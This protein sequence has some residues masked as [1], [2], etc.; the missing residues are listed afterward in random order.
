MRPIDRG[1]APRSY[2]QYGDA[3]EDLTAQLGQYCSYCERHIPVGLAVEHVLPKSL[4]PALEKTWTNFLLSC[5]NCN[6]VKGSQAVKIN[7][8][9]WPDRDNTF[10]AIIYSKGGFVTLANNLNTKQ[11]ANAQALLDLVGLQRH[12][13][14]GWDRPARRDK[15]WQDRENVWTAAERCKELF[16]KLGKSVEARELV[17]KFAQSRGFFSIWMIVFENYPDVKRELIQLL[18]GTATPCFDLNGKPLSRP[19]ATI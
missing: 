17:L 8:L 4:H 7:K 6:S 9:L 18:P 5:T 11:Q 16:D 12:P 1:L 10:L 3:I 19:G 13:A 2:Q 14:D 15:H